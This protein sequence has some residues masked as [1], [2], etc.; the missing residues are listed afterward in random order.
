MTTDSSTVYVLNCM[1]LHRIRGYPGL[2]RRSGSWIEEVQRCRYDKGASPHGTH[3]L[4]ARGSI[5]CKR[6]HRINR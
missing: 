4:A 5:G 1:L 3:R 2:L 6:R